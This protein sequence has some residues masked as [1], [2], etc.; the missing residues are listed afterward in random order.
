MNKITEA[1]DNFEEFLL[2]DLPSKIFPMH[3]LGD[4][5]FFREDFFETKKQVE[6]YIEEHFKVFRKEVE[7]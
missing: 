3:R 4:E 6:E 7:K 1:I 5:T 2:A